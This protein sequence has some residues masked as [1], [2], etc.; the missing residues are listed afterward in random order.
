M[1]LNR[2]W[3]ESG[4]ARHGDWSRDELEAMDAKFCEAVEQAFQTGL[5]SRTAA[6]STAAVRVGKR[7]VTEEQAI[8]TVW[9]WFCRHTDVEDIAFADVVARVRVLLPDVT[10]ARVRAGFEKRFEVN[11]RVK[12]GG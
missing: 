8:E 10:A 3:Y 4:D 2:G 1:L 11:P 7:R 12:F 9:R 5:E 6:R